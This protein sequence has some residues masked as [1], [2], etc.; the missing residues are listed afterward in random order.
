M[1]PVSEWPE[2]FR[3]Q[4]IL[5]Q[6]Q[7]KP[8][9]DH[10]IFAFK[11]HG[12]TIRMIVS[13][14]GEGLGEPGRWEH[15]S[16]SLVNRCPSWEEMCIVKNLF[17]DRD[18]AVLQYHPPEEEYVNHHPYCLHLWKL[19]ARDFNMVESMAR[20]QKMV[21]ESIL[22][23]KFIDGT[24]LSNDIACW[25][26]EAELAGSRNFNNPRPPMIAVGPSP[27]HEQR[28]PEVSAQKFIDLFKNCPMWSDHRKDSITLCTTGMTKDQAKVA[29]QTLRAIGFNRV[30]PVFDGAEA[31]VKVI[32]DPALEGTLLDTTAPPT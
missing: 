18:E 28:K 5:P 11:R 7:T 19:R 12:E 23:A 13:S 6:Y 17:W 22:W 14:G 9:D 27:K 16:V 2:H 3:R 1:K 8:G 21:E 25:L 26:A 32:Y 20:Y 30:E 31:Y 24:P 29:I 4:D 10:G 15:V